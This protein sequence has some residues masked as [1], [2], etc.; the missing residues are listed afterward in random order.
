MP[1]DGGLPS[2]TDLLPPRARLAYDEDGYPYVDRKPLNRRHR[3]QITYAS[4]VLE[5]RYADRPDVAADGLMTLHYQEGNRNAFVEP[6]LVVAFGVRPIRDRSSIK[7]WEEPT[8]AF[9]LEVLSPSTYENDLGPKH[10]LYE[11]LGIE[12]Y[13]LYDPFGRWIEERLR[14]YRLRGGVYEAVTALAAPAAPHAGH[15]LRSDA[16]DLELHDADGHL[17]F[18]DPAAR[19][20]LLPLADEAARADAEAARADAEAARADAEAA[21]AAREA[22]ARRAGEARIAELEALLRK[23]TGHRS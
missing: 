12:E 18:Y 5:R 3:Q 11:T 6:D 8:P 14:A 15:V 7:L 17:R 10:R 22:E 1:V 21:I 2:G 16:L 19:C 20:Y 23:S 13:W 9:V 4:P